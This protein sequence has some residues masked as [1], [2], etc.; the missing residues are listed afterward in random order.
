MLVVRLDFSCVAFLCSGLPVTRVR[1]RTCVGYRRRCCRYYWAISGP[2]R[3]VRVLRHLIVNPCIERVLILFCF[4][5]YVLVHLCRWMWLKCVCS[6]HL[7]GKTNVANC[8]SFSTNVCLLQAAYH[9]WCVHAHAPS[10]HC[11][12]CLWHSQY[13]WCSNAMGFSLLRPPRCVR[14]SSRTLVSYVT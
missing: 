11:W 2:A 12:R 10:Q 9:G 8:Q 5:H 7:L 3:L 1:C 14:H 6:L 13:V 4:L